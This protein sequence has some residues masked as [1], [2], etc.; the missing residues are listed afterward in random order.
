M[1]KHAAK[2]ARKRAKREAYI[3]SKPKFTPLLTDR[4]R[5]ESEYAKELPQGLS[6]IQQC[7]TL[8]K[9]RGNPRDFV[10]L[11]EHAKL[12]DGERVFQVRANLPE[13]LEVGNWVWLV[14]TSKPEQPMKPAIVKQ[15]NGPELLLLAPNGKTE[16][17]QDRAA[18]YPTSVP[19]RAT[20]VHK[21]KLADIIG[22]DLAARWW[23]KSLGRI[24]RTPRVI[25]PTGD[26]A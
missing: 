13:K 1:D 26:E 17:V 19:G 25:R 8:H 24:V 4:Q 21:S 2:Q 6:M 18:C 23:D 3:K 7:M 9:K 11:S 16:W 20:P 12:Y 5:A 10:V 22:K 15:D 14:D